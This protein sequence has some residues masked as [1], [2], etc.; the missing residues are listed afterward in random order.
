LIK[1]LLFL[2]WIGNYLDCPKMDKQVRS[3]VGA[4]EAIAFLTVEP[5]D[6]PALPLGHVYC[7]FKPLLRVDFEGKRALLCIPGK[8]V[9]EGSWALDLDLL[10]EELL[11]VATVELNIDLR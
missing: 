5:L 9:G 6:G 7:A 1:D 3:G 4:D 10:R 2:H 11:Y 8:D